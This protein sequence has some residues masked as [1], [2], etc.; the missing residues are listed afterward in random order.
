MILLEFGNEADFRIIDKFAGVQVDL[1]NIQQER[2][3]FLGTHSSEDI[4]V[5]YCDYLIQKYHMSISKDELIL[6]R[7]S[8]VESILTYELMYNQVFRN[9][10]EN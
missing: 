8:S 5:A 7:W 10:C 4:Y 1:N 2:D 3:W 9:C 6:E